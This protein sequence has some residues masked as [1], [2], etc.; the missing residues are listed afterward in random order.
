MPE[1][2]ETAMSIAAQEWKAEWKAEGQAEGRAE[3]LLRILERKFGPLPEGARVRVAAATASD[4]DAWL[5]RVIDSPA[6]DA[7]IGATH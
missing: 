5:D 3:A 1:H 7:V 2:E 6:L 4:V